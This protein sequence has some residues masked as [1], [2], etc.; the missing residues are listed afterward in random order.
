MSEACPRIRQTHLRHLVEHCPA[1][2]YALDVRRMLGPSGPGALRGQA[3]HRFFRLYL[4]RLYLTRRATDWDA[5]EPILAQVLTEYP[6]LTPEQWSDVRDQAHGITQAVIMRPEAFYGSEELLESAV[7]LSDG[8]R[9][10]ITGRL[11]FLEVADEVAFVIDVKSNHQI[12]PDAA[13]RRDFQLAVYAMLV[14]DNLPEVQ[15]V[16]GSLLMSRYGLRLPQKGEAVWTR[17]DA[18]DLR[19]YLAPKLEA[20]LAGR[21]KGERIPGTWCAYCPLRRTNE[22][23]LYRSYYGTTPPP[24]LS[25]ERAARLA[26]QVM[27]L[28]EA[29]EV[30]LELLK[31]YVSEQGPVTVGSHEHAEVF[32]FHQRETEEIEAGDFLRVVE[33]HRDLVGLPDPSLYLTVNK[34]SRAYKQ[35]RYHPDLKPD[36]DDLAT[37]RVS[38]VFGH[39]APGGD[40]DP[41]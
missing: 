2:A 24:P 8:G 11:D 22:C 20:H 30:R 15:L 39:K 37:T 32:A 17:D 25:P 35:L 33:A 12:P 16:Q 9:V 3:V 14:L 19:A 28:E 38:T 21:L 40:D 4:D 29:R 7:T 5:V 1:M 36:L 23:T 27:A 18:A 6:T 10:F 31:Q 34:R 41:R 13:V 26:R